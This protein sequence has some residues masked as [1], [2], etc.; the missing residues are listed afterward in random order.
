MHSRIIVL[1]RDCRPEMMLKVLETL[2][3]HINRMQEEYIPYIPGRYIVTLI[4]QR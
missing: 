3:V 4:Q 1:Y 2:K